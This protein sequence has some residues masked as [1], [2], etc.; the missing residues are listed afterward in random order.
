MSLVFPTPMRPLQILLVEDDDGDVKAI[1][2]AFR[3]SRII[4]PIVRAAD[5]VE[6]LEILR[7]EH[8]SVVEEPFVVLVDL[9][10]PRMNGHE[11]IAE[12]RRDPKLTAITAFVL[13]TSGDRTDIERAY[14]HHVAGYIMKDRAGEDFIDLVSTLENY[15]KV[16]ELPINTKYHA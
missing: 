10:M 5:G 14:G 12:L 1:R 16:V 7:G 8:E 4:N 3:N 13:T 15:W 11:F 9:N 6:A 2:R